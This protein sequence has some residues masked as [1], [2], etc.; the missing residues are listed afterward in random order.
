MK[1]KT[2][3][4]TMDFIFLLSD[5]KEKIYINMFKRLNDQSDNIRQ[6]F[7]GTVRY[8]DCPAG[9]KMHH[10][11]PG[12]L[13]EHYCEMLSW[14]LKNNKNRFSDS[15]IFESV[16]LHDISKVFLYRWATP[17]EFAKEPLHFRYIKRD[18]KLPSLTDDYLTFFMIQYFNLNV[19]FEVFNAVCFAEGGWSDVAKIQGNQ[20]NKLGYFLHMADLYS[21]QFLGK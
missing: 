12:G 21:S 17:E 11:Q 19:S 7:P 13:Q 2:F 6:L 16:I 15:D 20:C 18:N 4:I 5:S 1:T 3:P 14:M 10:T 9:Y 8:S